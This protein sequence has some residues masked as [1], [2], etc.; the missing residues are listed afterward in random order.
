MSINL[1][2]KNLDAFN[3]K[4]N[5]KLQDNKVKAYVTRASLMVQNTAKESI[6]KGGTGILYQKYEPRRSHRASAPNEPP[7]SDT[8]FLVS[9]IKV[10]KKSP[11][12]VVV[13]STAPYSAFLEFGTSQMGER[14]FMHPAAMRAFP[15]I[16]K[17]VFNKVVEKV[18]EF[19]I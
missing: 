16:A 4:L 13:Q 10:Q 1:R 3:K 9:N 17:A 15:K 19:K 11:D 2:I 6:T 12:E 5:K 18:K 14:P 8:G 7:A